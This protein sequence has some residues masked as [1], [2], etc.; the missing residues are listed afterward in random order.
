VRNTVYLAGKENFPED[1]TEEAEGLKDSNA[2]VTKKYALE[3]KVI[4]YP[5]VFYMPHVAPD[6]VFDYIEKGE[7]PE[8]P[9]IFMPALLPRPLI[10]CRSSLSTCWRRL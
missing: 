9:Y 5:V 2:Y 10:R 1:Y 8:E 7:P 4:P 3:R 6:R